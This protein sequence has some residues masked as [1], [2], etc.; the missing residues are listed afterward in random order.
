MMKKTKI[1]EFTSKKNNYLKLAKQALPI[2]IF[3][4]CLLITQNELA[5][6]IV[7]IFMTAITF[8]ISYEKNEYRVF[9]LG[10][11]LGLVMEIGGDAI[12]KMQYWDNG[13]LFG[14]PIWLPFLWAYGFI[15][16]RRIGNI[17]IK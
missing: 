15:I 7:L 12:Y 9:L 14:I 17:I 2:I 16:I 10:L 3:P 4:I 6:A 1:S 11:I 8:W 5:I 13:S